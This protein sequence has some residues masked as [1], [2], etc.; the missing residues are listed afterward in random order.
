LYSLHS[1]N[2]FFT[3]K[4]IRAAIVK[5]SGAF[6]FWKQDHSL[7]MKE[8]TVKVENVELQFWK[9]KKSESCESQK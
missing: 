1:G 6:D 8:P 3:E 9:V 4:R 2:P 5:L 7:R